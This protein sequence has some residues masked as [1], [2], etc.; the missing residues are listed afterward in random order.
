[1][2]PTYGLDERQYPDHTQPTQL[3]AYAVLSV[4]PAQELPALVG[5]AAVGDLVL[6]ALQHDWGQ[7]VV[8]NAFHSDVGLQKF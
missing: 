1:M 4:V 3:A 5:G 7:L 2:K 6:A 8:I